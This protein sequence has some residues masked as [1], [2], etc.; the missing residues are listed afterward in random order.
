MTT[1]SPIRHT[2][3]EDRQ[4]CRV[5]SIDGDRQLAYAEYGRP[6]GI[7]VVFHHG[8]PGSRRFGA[9]LEPAAQEYG[10]RVLAPERPGYGRSSPW[11][12][13]SMRD[14]AAFV[15]PVLDDAEIET[16]NLVAFSGGGPYAL[17]TAAH[18]PDRIRHVDIIAGATPPTSSEGRPAIQQLM[19][20]AAK[21]T[22]TTLRGLFRG[23][24][25]LAERLH[26]SFVVGQYTATPDAVPDATA[27]L[28]RDDFVEA[29][30]RSRRG[31]V[32][33]L[34]EMATGWHVDYSEIATDVRLWHGTDDTN[35]PLEDAQ[36]LRQQLPSATLHTVDDADHLQTV[37][38]CVPDVLRQYR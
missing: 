36:R 18:R 7:P 9:L 31:A 32:T 29:F 19:G 30:T 10:I 26:P 16:A 23:Q 13:R 1:S 27:T 24:A 17:S 25:W 20:W 8:T 22:P 5:V 6:D 38:R 4:Q 2:P 3:S 12:S 15:E 14:A 11:P 34:R 21:T 28:V 35:V 33:E 37:L